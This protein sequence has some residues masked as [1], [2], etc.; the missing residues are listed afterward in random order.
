MLFPAGSILAFPPTI[1]Q[2]RSL[3]LGSRH[4]SKDESRG[5]PHLRFLQ[6]QS[7]YPFSNPNSLSHQRRHWEEMLVHPLHLFETSNQ[8]KRDVFWFQGYIS[9]IISHPA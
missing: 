8:R 9:E 1:P 5:E 7:F 6:Q 2:S 3:W 4:F